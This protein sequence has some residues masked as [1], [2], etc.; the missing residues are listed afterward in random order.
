MNVDR[1]FHNPSICSH[2]GGNILLRLQKLEQPR[3]Q[4]F[5][6]K[7]TVQWT[8]TLQH[9]QFK[10]NFYR[11]LILSPT[12]SGVQPWRR[13]SGQ[14]LPHRHLQHGPAAW[15]RLGRSLQRVSILH[16]GLSS[17][18]HTRTSTPTH[19]LTHPNTHTGTHSLTHI[20]HTH[21]HYPAPPSTSVPH[22]CTQPLTGSLTPAH[23]HTHLRT[24]THTYPHTQTLANTHYTNM[25]PHAPHTLTHP[26]TQHNSHTLTPTTHIHTHI[27]AECN[28]GSELLHG[29]TP[30]EKSGET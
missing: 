29:S 14:C 3:S 4:R 17:H 24:H 2:R 5:T 15:R 20:H 13:V 12:D 11:K 6:R 8:Q 21:T 7:G 30:S 16:H 19:T 18:T 22:I 1:T 26:H 10:I 23:T 27:R 25:P 9:F 28:W